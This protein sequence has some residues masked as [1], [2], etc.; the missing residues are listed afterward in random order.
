MSSRSKSPIRVTFDREGLRLDGALLPLFAGAVHYW[1]LDPAHWRKALREVHALGFRLVDVYVPWD[2]HETAKDTF[3]FGQ[4][5]PSKD[6]AEFL[7]IA[8]ELDLYAIVRPGPHIN[9]EMTCFGVPERI[10]WKRACQARSSTGNA[11]ML[12]SP[13]LAF[14]VPSYASDAFLKQANKFF[15]ALGEVLSP[16]RHPEGPIVMV[17]VD[18]EG[19][20]YFRD[21]LYDQDYHPDAIAL[22]REYLED[23]YGKTAAPKDVYGLGGDSFETLEP[24][25][26]FDARTL[27]DLPRHL[28]WAAFQEHMV[29]RFFRRTEK[30]L[31]R[32]GFGGLPTAHNIAMADNTTVLGQGSVQHTVDIVGLDYYYLASPAARRTIARRTSELAVRGD[33]HDRPSFACE[34][35]A[36]F[37]PFM[38]AMTL[39]D[40]AFTL[41]TALAYGLRGFNAYMAVERDRWIGAPIDAKGRV[42]PS[43][44]FWKRLMHTLERVRFSSLRRRVPVR[45]VTPRV[46]IRITRVMHAFGPLSSAAF[47]GLGRGAASHCFDD[48]FGTGAPL[49]QQAEGFVDTVESVLERMNVSF[50]HVGDDALEACVSGASWVL[51]AVPG[52][53]IAPALLERLERY[54]AAGGHVTFGPVWPCRDESMRPLAAPPDEEAWAARAGSIPVRLPSDADAMGAA[55]ATMAARGD[56]GVWEVT[57]ASVAITVHEDHDGQPRVLFAI[58]AEPDEVEA[59][60]AVGELDRATDA[61]TGE[62]LEVKAGGVRITLPGKTVRMVELSEFTTE[63]RRH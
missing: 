7:R 25:V 13:P 17:Q 62:H 10:I 1:R 43:A 27:E 16:L 20:L 4:T 37:P 58:N 29:L 63:A 8:Q 6:I 49:A 45:I 59:I 38:A 22:Y 14:P 54:A 42:R 51:V 30:R 44:A 61:M 2:V 57:P 28:D 15:R 56:L 35:G 41:M 50:A 11:V 39:E 52:G 31:R 46:H 19:A 60:V 12:P 26:R 34:I 53:A 33:V 3:D 32:A 24:P 5:D 23:K 40:N 9:A 36:G 48:D 21:A 55:A 18:N 47:A